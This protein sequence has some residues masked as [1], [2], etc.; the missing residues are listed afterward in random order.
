MSM[1]K[2]FSGMRYAVK[3][4]QILINTKYSSAN[5]EGYFLKI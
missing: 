1:R 4:S 5:V 3:I 2:W